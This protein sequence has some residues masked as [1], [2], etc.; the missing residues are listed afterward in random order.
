MNDM[1]EY[2]YQQNEYPELNRMEQVHFWPDGDY[3]YDEDLD[4]YLTTKSDDYKSLPL[5]FVS[6]Y[7]PVAGWKAVMYTWSPDLGI[8]EPEQTGFWAYDTKEEAEAGARSWAEAEEVPF[9]TAD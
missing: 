3:C 5:V 7:Q 4:D 6:V 8:Y 9:V 2:N 1:N